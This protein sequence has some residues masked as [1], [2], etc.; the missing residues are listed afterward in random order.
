MYEN[1][2]VLIV[3][4]ES[5]IAL[6]LKREMELLGF[7]ILKTVPTGEEAITVINDRCP[8]LILLDISLAGEMT[9]LDVARSNG[10]SE[11]SELIIFMTGYVTPEIK[12][13]AMQLEPIG[14]LEKPVDVSDILKL[15][16]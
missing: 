14:F 16:N 5:I 8:N 1:Y 13:E 9:G 11:N 6:C 10:C 12:Q 7:N 2:K 4:D 3:E 15:L